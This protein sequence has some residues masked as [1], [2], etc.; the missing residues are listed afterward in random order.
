MKDTSSSLRMLAQVDPKRLG[1]MMSFGHA[2]AR[3]ALADGKADLSERD[4]MVEALRARKTF[5]GAEIE[6]VVDLALAQAQAWDAIGSSEEERRE[7]AL[8]LEA[9][10]AADSVVTEDERA[11][12]AEML[13]HS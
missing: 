8:A 4:A 10:A 3:V 1:R 13:N 9:V 11:V 12:I 2:L 5:S 6:L 7:L